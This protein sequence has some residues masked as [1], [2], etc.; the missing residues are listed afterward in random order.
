MKIHRRYV[1]CPYSKTSQRTG[2]DSE[3]TCIACLKTLVREAT[4]YVA[5]A[6][7]DLASEVNRLANLESR[8]ESELF[9]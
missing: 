9:V 7:K 4:R 5:W 2:N 6:E 3:V 8:L 1:G